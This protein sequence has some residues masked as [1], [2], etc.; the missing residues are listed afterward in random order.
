MNNILDHLAKALEENCSSPFLPKGFVQ[1]Q[2][3]HFTDGEREL[4]IQI[5][6]RDFTLNK[7][8]DCTGSGSRVGVGKNW[9]IQQSPAES[10]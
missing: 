4:N 5:G 7:D 8:L 6:D 2:F 1:I 3:A 9:N 10:I